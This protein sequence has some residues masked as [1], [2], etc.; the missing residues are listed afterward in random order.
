M[1]HNLLIEGDTSHEMLRYELDA[2]DRLRGTLNI[3]IPLEED[4]FACVYILEEVY[5][6]LK[7]KARLKAIPLL[8]DISDTMPTLYNTWDVGK[9]F[10]PP[11]SKDL[12]LQFFDQKLGEIPEELD[13]YYSVR[14]VE[15]RPPG[16]IIDLIIVIPTSDRELEYQIYGALR[17]LTIK[18]VDLL[19]NF[20]II[21]SRGR[22]LNE[23]ISEGYQCYV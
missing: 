4:Y 20:R 21:R 3:P 7:G 6:Q 8:Q 11:S 5:P 2:V 9:T 16:Y 19:F 17:D 1:M 15:N 14:E 18:Y 23:I 10:S 13:F 22:P 12:A